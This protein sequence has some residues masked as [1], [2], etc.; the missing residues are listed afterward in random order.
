MQ[1]TLTLRSVIGT[2]Y[3]LGINVEDP[4]ATVFAWIFNFFADF[5]ILSVIVV[6][7]T[8]VLLVYFP[9]TIMDVNDEKFVVF[10]TTSTGLMSL[11]TTISAWSLNECNFVLMILRQANGECNPLNL[12]RLILITTAFISTSGFKLSLVFTNNTWTEG[13]RNILNSKALILM[14]VP[15]IIWAIL[16]RIFNDQQEAISMVASTLV[17]PWFPIVV[18]SCSDN[19]WRFVV[20]R[21]TRLCQCESFVLQNPTTTQMNIQT[22]RVSPESIELN[23]M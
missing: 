7:G 23:N 10:M 11:A 18:I 13:E 20:N 3:Y 21:L 22:Q 4:Q 19:L 12:V 15:F 8:N 2:V 6:F 9:S 16:L 17:Y 14:I 5:T 1:I